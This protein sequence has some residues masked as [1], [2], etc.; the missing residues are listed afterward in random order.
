MY[1][2][3]DRSNPCCYKLRYV[4]LL[5]LFGFTVFVHAQS[6]P[7][8][9]KKL[10]DSMNSVKQ[11]NLNKAIEIGKKGVQVARE[12]NDTMMLAIISDNISGIFLMMGKYDSATFYIQEAMSWYRFC[13]NEMDILWCRYYLLIALSLQGLY[14]EAISECQQVL[15]SPHINETQ[16]L[17]IPVLNELGNI[18][19]RQSLYNK[20]VEAYTEARSCVR[21]DT[22]QFISLSINLGAV[23]NA[24]KMYDSSIIVL[25]EG[26]EY[27]KKGNW[28]LR[29]ASLLTTMSDNWKELGRFNDAI[30]CIDEAIIIREEAEDSIGLS[31][32][33]RSKGNILVAKGAYNLANDYYFKSLKI[34]ESLNIPDNTAATYCS[35]GECL[36]YKNDHEAAM[37][38][39]GQ[40]HD[41]AVKIGAGAAIEAALKGMALSSMALHNTRQAIDFMERYI[42]VHDSIVSVDGGN[43]LVSANTSPSL[44]EP[45]NALKRLATFL[46]ISLLIC[47]IILLLYRNRNLRTALKRDADEKNI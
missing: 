12:T 21:H 15:Q 8:P 20:A 29:K 40:G 33:Y 3:T 41:I 37:A 18:Y 32:S 19:Y 14:D 6:P 44:K 42:T 25:Q 34:D 10:N 43:S 13:G 45:K 22:T 4:L 7:T 46:G 24:M 35:I 23:L 17:Y 30:T 9:A 38:Y 11:T 1:P 27:A 39:F 2:P 28:T 26:L 31:Y 5:M 16:A 47:T 36:Q